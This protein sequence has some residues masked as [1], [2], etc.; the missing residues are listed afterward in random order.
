M[1]R[2]IVGEL[3][4]QVGLASLSA[5]G[6]VRLGFLG[7][8]LFCFENHRKR[9]LD[10]LGFPWISRPKRDLSMGYTGFSLKNF[11]RAPLPLGVRSGGTEGPREAMGKRGSVHRASLRHILIF[12]NR[13][14]PLPSPAR[15]IGLNQTRPTACPRQGPVRAKCGRSPNGAANGSGRPRAEVSSRVC[16]HA[17]SDVNGRLLA[18][19]LCSGGARILEIVDVCD[20]DHSRCDPDHSGASQ[21]VI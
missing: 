13:L 8:R 11:S 14:S 15:L 6:R 5:P 16:G 1:P 12:C 19:H 2:S 21:I 9:G 7:R 4:L 10:F 18:R 20:P 17:A 3:L